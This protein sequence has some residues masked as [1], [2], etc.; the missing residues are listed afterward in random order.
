MA[1]RS[2]ASH[3][4]ACLPASRTVQASASERDRATPASTSVSSTLRSGWR[5]RVI[6]GTDNWVNMI[7]SPSTVTPQA[8]RLP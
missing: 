2:S 8:T 1:L 5:S 6:T 4:S 7:R 3:S